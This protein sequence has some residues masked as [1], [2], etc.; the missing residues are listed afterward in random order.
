MRAVNASVLGVRAAYAA[1]VEGAV[2][3]SQVDEIA[4][5]SLRAID[6]PAQ[7]ATENEL[8]EVFAIADA[9][10]AEARKTQQAALRAAASRR[11][12]PTSAPVAK[13]GGGTR[14]V[15]GEDRDG[16]SG[17][18]VLGLLGAI[19]S[20]NPMAIVEHASTLLPEKSPL[21]VAV[22]GAT[23]LAKGDYRTALDSAK[24]LSPEGSSLRTALDSAES[25]VRT[26]RNVAKEAQEVT[27][28][29]NTAAR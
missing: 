15:A 27:N 24:S 1:A 2:S 9:Q 25:S 19:T 17:G 26:V 3:P 8:D 14:G 18:G 29:P 21:R 4:K 28:L 22:R 10:L 6:D 12:A 5:A 23:A 7:P 13:A 16:S 11:V 20:G